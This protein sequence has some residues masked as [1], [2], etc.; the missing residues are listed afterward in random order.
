M[1]FLRLGW[2]NFLMLCISETNWQIKEKLDKGVSMGPIS[3]PNFITVLEWCG[4]DP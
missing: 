2:G 3:V 1:C 4:W